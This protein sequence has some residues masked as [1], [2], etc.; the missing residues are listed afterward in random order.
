MTTWIWGK[1]VDEESVDGEIGN[2][3]WKCG[4]R[5]DNETEGEEFTKGLVMLGIHWTK[6]MTDG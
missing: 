4:V 6:G 2:E 3:I 1:E 5:G